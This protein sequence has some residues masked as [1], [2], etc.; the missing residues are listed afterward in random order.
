MRMR[1]FQPLQWPPALRRFWPVGRAVEHR[2]PVQV[3][4]RD[5]IS[6]ATWIIVFGIGTS[7]LLN[8]PTFIF[9][10]SALGS[11]MSIPLGQSTLTAVL[12]AVI[13]A[14]G[15]E[16]VVSVHPLFSASGQGRG[17]T[18]AFWALPMALVLINVLLLPLAP[19]QLVQV[20]M[21]PL[22]GVLLALTFFGLYATVESG[23]SGFR[24]SRF[25]LDALTYGSALLLFLLVYQTRTRSL[26]SGSLIAG[27]ATLLAV[28]LLRSTTD[29]VSVVLLYGLIVGVIL[30]Q[31]TWA[32]N[33]W[34]LPDLVGGLLLL[35]IFYLLT[36]IAQ[37]GIQGRLTQR[38][39]IE[40]AL[41]AT[42]ALLLIAFVGRR[43][44]L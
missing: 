29:R 9:S 6:I 26:L 18:W 19:T 16:S 8:V 1:N 20:L 14:T 37:Q 11:P 44:S 43:I 23:Q 5:R 15:A 42:V 30:G 4:Y 39:L 36:G 35:L 41:F 12:L 25:L 32:L 34:L 40:F 33:Y 3:D 22:S 2:R 21:L 24:R 13:A 28:E 10:F 27:T 38:V 17:R 31:V 7:M